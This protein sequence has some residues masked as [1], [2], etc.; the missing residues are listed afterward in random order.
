AVGVLTLALGIGAN[1]AIFSVLSAVVLRPL[2]FP[3]PDRLVMLRERNLNAGYDENA[4]AAANYLDWQR[5]N[6]VFEEMA[7]YDGYRHFNLQGGDRP[8]R[9]AGAAATAS[10]FPLLGIQPLLGRTFALEEEQVER[11]QVVLLSY[12]LWQERFNGD[13]DIVGKAVTL[14]GTSRTVIG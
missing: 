13:R 1:T 3:Q 8:E 2:P 9:V 10:L 5:E 14:D 6:T 12:G 11:D 7:A 4:P